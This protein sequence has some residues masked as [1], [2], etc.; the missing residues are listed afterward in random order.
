MTRATQRRRP[1]SEARRAFQPP[2][3][4]RI[5]DL[6]GD[7][8]VMELPRFSGTGHSVHVKSEELNPTGSVRDR[9][10]AEVFAGVGS[11]DDFER[12][13]TVVARGLD[14][15]SV[16]VAFWATRVGVDCRI[17]AP[18]GGSRRLAPLVERYGAE[19]EWVDGRGADGWRTASERAAR[20]ADQ[21]DARLDVA[22]HRSD[23]EQ[24]PDELAREL[25]SDASGADARSIVLPASL[26]GTFRGVGRRMAEA[27]GEVEI[28][29]AAVGRAG[30]ALE[31][32]PDEGRVESLPSER[33]WE[34]RDR[35]ARTD[36]LL[37]GPRGAAVAAVGRRLTERAGD[38]EEVLGLNPD[39]GQ[40]YLGWEDEL[41]R[42]VDSRRLQIH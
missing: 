16:S 39:A 28:V 2:S 24:A 4:T 20:W 30:D 11:R 26:E 7:T 32:S 19:I 31:E 21:A 37:L 34:V 25:I 15:W 36:G 38:G 35:V 6:V 12:I 22:A 5:E 40:R 18:E 23:V 8:P 27:S 17:V 10:L 9:Y 13:T 33:V 1:V 42:A 29:Y 41:D 3:R 14:D